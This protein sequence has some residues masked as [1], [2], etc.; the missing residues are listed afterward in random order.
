[1][2][3]TSIKYSGLDSVSTKQG[4]DRLWS[5]NS[6]NQGRLNDRMVLVPGDHERRS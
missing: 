4:V 2:A 5:P 1:M 3:S 6:A